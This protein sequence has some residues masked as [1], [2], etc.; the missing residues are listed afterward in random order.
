MSKLDEMRQNFKDEAD[1][2]RKDRLDRSTKI[3]AIIAAAGVVI[4]AIIEI[5]SKWFTW[6]SH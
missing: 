5:I 2:S 4:S 6:K 1:Q 3:I